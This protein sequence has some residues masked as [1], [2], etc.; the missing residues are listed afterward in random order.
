M[1]MLIDNLYLRLL[2][3]F[4]YQFICTLLFVYVI[5]IFVV[6]WVD[7]S[8]TD[9]VHVTPGQRSVRSIATG[10]AQTTCVECTG[11]I[12]FIKVEYYGW[13][14]YVCWVVMR[15]IEVLLLLLSFSEYLTYYTL[16]LSVGLVDY[17]FMLIL[18][19]FYIRV[20]TDGGINYSVRQYVL[21]LR[22]DSFRYNVAY[23]YI[24]IYIGRNAAIFGL[25]IFAV[26]RHWRERELRNLDTVHII[27]TYLFG[28]MNWLLYA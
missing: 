20:H 22:V 13:L 11:H 19:S 9:S 15:I 27:Y 5:R 26:Q 14:R 16:Y 12:M 10:M 8:V 18:S 6:R 23:I 7:L 2:H 1:F 4:A 28:R 3:T 25:M 24:Y 17:C 21:S